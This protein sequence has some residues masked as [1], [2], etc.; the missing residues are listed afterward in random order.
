MTVKHCSIKIFSAPKGLVIMYLEGGG[1]KYVGK[2]KISLR[3]PLWTMCDPPS[4]FNIYVMTP[5][6]PT[7]YLLLHALQSNY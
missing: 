1:E 6:P 2:I 3:P 7:S 4:L 5:P